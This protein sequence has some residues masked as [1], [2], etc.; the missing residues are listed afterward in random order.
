MVE[1]VKVVEVVEGVIVGC[2]KLLGF[3]DGSDLVSPRVG[4][5]DL[6]VDCHLPHNG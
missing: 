3:L 5:I 6:Q 2:K 1:V 4:R